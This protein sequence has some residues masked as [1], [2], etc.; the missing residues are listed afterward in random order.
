MAHLINELT[1]NRAGF[2]F[3]K[4]RRWDTKARLL[5]SIEK[6]RH[7]IGYQPK[8]DFEEGVKNT[9]DWFREHWD[10]IRASARF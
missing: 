8:T 9:V 1:G 7:L 2:V 3:Q 10:Q 6:A 4:R 5:A